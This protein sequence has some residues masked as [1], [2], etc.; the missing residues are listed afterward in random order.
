MASESKSAS[1]PSASG[2]LSARIPAISSSVVSG[3]RCVTNA[4]TWSMTLL[5]GTSTAN[6]L[7]SHDRPLKS[8][9]KKQCLAATCNNGALVCVTTASRTVRR[10]SPFRFP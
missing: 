2:N 9:S 8:T 4:I 5:P 6:L 7:L 3:N 10:E 1:I